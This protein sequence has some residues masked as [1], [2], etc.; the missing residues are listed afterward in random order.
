MNEENINKYI[1]TLPKP[2]QN[3]LSSNNLEE[4]VLEIAKKYSLNAEQSESLL[5][6]VFL[7]VVGV[8]KTDNIT[9]LIVSD[10]NTSRLLAEQIVQDLENR[11][12]DY[13][14]K[15]I[16]KENVSS[17]DTKEKIMSSSTQLELKPDNLPVVEI[18]EPLKVNPVPKP[19]FQNE[20]LDKQV[21]GVPRYTESP[22]TAPVI[23]PIVEKKINNLTSATPIKYEKDPYREPL[24]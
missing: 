23:N 12:F 17:V 1:S 3:F 19:V 15:Q 13:A 8:I 22:R 5:N 4:R 16:E 2:L 20:A 18:N 21:I 14:L 11:V 6:N 24:G 10:L 9:E 7:M